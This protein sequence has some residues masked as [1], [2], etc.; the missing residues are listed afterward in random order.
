MENLNRITLY[1]SWTPLG[2]S[3]EVDFSFMA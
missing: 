3:D 2:L 1:L